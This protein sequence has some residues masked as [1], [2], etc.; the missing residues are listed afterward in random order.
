VNFATRLVARNDFLHCLN[1]AGFLLCQKSPTVLALLA[2]VLP[3]NHPL[4]PQLSTGSVKNVF[5]K[6]FSCVK[7]LKK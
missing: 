7:G 6:A 5:K 1:P 2:A 4:H 3:N